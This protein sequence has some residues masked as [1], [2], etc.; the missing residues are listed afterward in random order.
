MSGLPFAVPSSV[1]LGGALALSL[2]ALVMAVVAL[3]AMRRERTR[4]A[5]E[6]EVVRGDMRA[7]VSAAVG[8]GERVMRLERQLTQL[9]ERQ[10]QLDLNDPAHQS[11]QQAIRMARRGSDM[12]ELIEVC[13][14]T[15]GEA[16]L[17][18]MLHRLEE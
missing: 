14:L 4:L 8:V 16:E 9:A 13:G 12:N 15:R 2:V 3:L 1:I 17:V 11:Y 10:D 6:A 5:R 7:L 18:T